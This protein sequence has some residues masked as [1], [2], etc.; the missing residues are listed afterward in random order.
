MTSPGWCS[1]WCARGGFVVFRRV[2]EV[3]ARA[4]HVPARLHPLGRRRR[5]GAPQQHVDFESRHHAAHRGRPASGARHDLARVL[6]CVERRAHPARRP[7]AVRLHARE[8]HVLPLAGRGLHSVRRAAAADARRAHPRRAHRVGG[9]RRQRI[10]PPGAIRRPDERARRVCRC[11]RRQR[12][13]RSRSQFHFV[14]HLRRRHCARSGSLS[15]KPLRR[16][17]HARRLHARAL[18]ASR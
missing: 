6:S 2:P 10:G 13:G 15:S 11:R 17:T 5:H 3:R 4:L 14:L 12:R 7:R 16:Q 8:H 18:A 9:R 1:G